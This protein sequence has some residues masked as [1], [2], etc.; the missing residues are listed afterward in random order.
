MRPAMDGSSS[1]I[2]AVIHPPEAVDMGGD[3]L[4]D[5]PM[6]EEEAGAE[7]ESV[8][9]VDVDAV[10]DATFFAGNIDAEEG[11]VDLEVMLDSEGGSDDSQV[12]R[13]VRCTM[14]TC[15]TVRS[16]R[17]LRNDTYECEIRNESNESK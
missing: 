3:A 17:V 15:S 9:A 13:I 4:V 5:A 10:A 6:G 2:D 14:R 1:S 7:S 12:G 8:A 11:D 16:T